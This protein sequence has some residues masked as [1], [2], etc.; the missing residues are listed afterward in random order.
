MKCRWF[1]R[2]MLIPIGVAV[3]PALL[4]CL[5]VLVAPTNW[6]RKHVV[7]ALERSSGRSVG[8]DSLRVCFGGGIDLKNLRIGAPDAPADPWL[9]ADQV[10]LDVGVFQIL[11]GRLDATALDVDGLDL[12]V[13]RRADGTFELAD[14]VHSGGPTRP[15]DGDPGPTGPTNLQIVVKRARIRVVD[16]PTRTDVVLE[17]VA[18]EGTWEEGRTITGSMSGDVNQG[19]FQFSGSLLRIPGRP[20]FEGR[21][22]ADGVV[23]DDGMAFLR[24]LVPVMAG[25]TPKVRGDVTMEMYLRGDGETRELLRQT[26]VGNGR[27][28][29]DPIQLD[30]TELLSEV[31]KSVTLPTR[32]RVGSLR[33]DV[34]VKDG[35][36]LTKKLALNIARAPLVIAGWTDFDGNLDYRMSLDGLAEKVPARARQLLAELDL[37][38][39]ALSS[40]QLHGTVDDLQV[41]VLGRTPGAGSMPD[42]QKLKLLGREIRDNLL[43]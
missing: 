43:R 20:A 17:N 34:A 33:T 36:I 23:L 31:E 28:L 24:Y 37:D 4:W 3:A 30:G 29:I 41:S 38:V 26:L 22:W 15:T 27:I 14:L 11:C 39:A 42:K 2:L 1:R 16:E 35:K 13:R 10:H 6:A 40:L 19:A 12:R 8:L 9:V 25:A 7:A 18:G 5:V 21:L 32:S